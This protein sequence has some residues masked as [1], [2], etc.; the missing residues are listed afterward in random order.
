MFCIQIYCRARSGSDKTLCNKLLS[1]V[2]VKDH[3]P[4]AGACCESRPGGPLDGNT[5]GSAFADLGESHLIGLSAYCRVFRTR[6][7]LLKRRNLH[8]SHVPGLYTP[9]FVRR[10]SHSPVSWSRLPLCILRDFKE[11]NVTSSTFTSNGLTVH[12]KMKGT[13]RGLTAC[14]LRAQMG[15]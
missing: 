5:G 6:R 8:E 2:C 12:L 1:P 3:A 4:A 14:Q 10:E 15:S 7:N 13:Q 9:S 11:K